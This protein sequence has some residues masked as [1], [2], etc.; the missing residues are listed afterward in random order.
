M[1]GA[2]TCHA[3]PRALRRRLTCRH[4]LV[5]V[6]SWIAR[7][8]P[9]YCVGHQHQR[10]HSR[11][12]R[13]AALP[14]QTQPTLA[15]GS[16]N[17]S[18]V[19]VR[20]FAATVG[21]SAVHS[22]AAQ[23][24]GRC[25]YPLAR[26]RRARV[27]RHLARGASP[28]TINASRPQS[29]RCLLSCTSCAHSVPSRRVGSG[30]RCVGVQTVLM[31]CTCTRTARQL[32]FMA[33]QRLSSCPQGLA[34]LSLRHGY[35]TTV[36]SPPKASHSHPHAGG[37]PAPVAGGHGTWPPWSRRLRSRRQPGI[38]NTC[39]MYAAHC[40]CESSTNAGCACGVY[41]VTTTAT[42]PTRTEPS[43]CA[44]RDSGGGSMAR[45]EAWP[46]IPATNYRDSA[47]L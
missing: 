38:I 30:A 43:R 4:V 44:A 12:R 47:S 3:A 45:V 31:R 24:H 33:T 29:P 1:Q 16:T 41:C 37:D 35:T 5:H 28:T 34:L 40:Y 21:S 27:T 36:L 2:T 39:P 26:G 20:G 18:V 14:V 17:S 10:H 25:T 7:W 15:D 6:R 32:C 19:L 8:S 46:S 13:V 11:S 22:A 9:A 42:V 23:C